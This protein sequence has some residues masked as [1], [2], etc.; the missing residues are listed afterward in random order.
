MRA[1][2][3]IVSQAMRKFKPCLGNVSHQILV[4]DACDTR[5]L[6][7]RSGTKYVSS[8]W[9]AKEK[10]LSEYRVLRWLED[11]EHNGPLPSAFGSSDGNATEEATPVNNTAE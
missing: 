11:Q 8:T 9:S 2:P 10:E 4:W 1:G 7:V 6:T 3:G 5:S